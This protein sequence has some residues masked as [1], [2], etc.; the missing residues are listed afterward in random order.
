[1]VMKLV[2]LKADPMVPW[3]DSLSLFREIGV[4]NTGD[5]G[6]F[7]IAEYDGEKPWTNIIDP[8]SVLDDHEAKTMKF[9]PV[10]IVTVG[11]EF[12]LSGVYADDGDYIVMVGDFPV[13][14]TVT[15]GK[16]S[17]NVTLSQAGVYVATCK[18][19]PCVPST[20]TVAL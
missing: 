12:T 19:V 6:V 11:T 15:G 4:F 8:Q 14:V 20:I 1:M 17:R 10:A 7:V 9:D 16:F 2:A 5:D 13:S 3:F 18:T